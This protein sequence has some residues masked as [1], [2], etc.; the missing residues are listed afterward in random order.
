MIGVVRV[1]RVGLLAYW[2]VS[3]FFYSS[4]SGLSAILGLSLVLALCLRAH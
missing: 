4:Y 3:G 2:V 1:T